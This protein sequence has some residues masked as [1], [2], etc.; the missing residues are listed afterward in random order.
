MNLKKLFLAISL[1]GIPFVVAAQSDLVG[2]WA[3]DIQLEE[4]PMPI[5]LELMEG[6]KFQVDLG[7][8]GSMEIKGEWSVNGKEV[9]FKDTEGAAACQNDQ[10]GTYAFEL[11]GKTVTFTRVNDPCQRGNPEGVMTMTRM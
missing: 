8:D 2:S 6:G 7:N 5:T 1:L 11:N 4:G 3:M 10:G 9:T